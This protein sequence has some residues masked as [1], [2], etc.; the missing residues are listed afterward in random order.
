VEG[1]LGLLAGSAHNKGLQMTSSVHCDIPASV[2]GDPVR[3]RQVLLNLVGNAVKFTSAGEVVVSARQERQ[4]E[5][6]VVLAF[7]VRDTG[8]GMSPELQ[9]RLFQPFTQGDGST[10]RRYGG[11]GLGL[12]ICHE[13]VALMGGSISAESRLGVGS[14]FRFSVRCKRST[15][16][17]TSARPSAPGPPAGIERRPSCRASI[18]LVEDNPVNEKLAEAILRKAGHDVTI[19]RTGAQALAVL[20][21]ATFD[22]VLMD[23]QMPEM[24]GWT[25]TREI[26]RR[27]AGTRRHQVVIALTAS[28][29]AGD[30]E[31]C[32]RSGMDD[33][34]AK[35]FRAMDLLGALDTWLPRTRP[36]WA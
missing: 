16:A 25:A 6:D 34:L 4:T 10:T 35:P 22:L 13:L 11:T 31:E 15:A 3:L 2:R 1:V 12:A 14:C 8:I 36:P 30:R 19:C 9:A 33:Y 17:A 5:D 27:E 20:A 29:M 32:L 28:A 7:E 18:L 21:E 26:R 24:D 23:C